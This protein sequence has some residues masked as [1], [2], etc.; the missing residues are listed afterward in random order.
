M[1]HKPLGVNLKGN[2][3]KGQISKQITSIAMCTYAFLIYSSVFLEAH[4]E[5]TQNM[6]KYISNITLSQQ[7]WWLWVEVL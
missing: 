3:I 7:I 5:Q 4:P 6:L 1:E 2:V